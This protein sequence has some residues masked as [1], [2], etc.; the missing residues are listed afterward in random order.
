MVMWITFVS[1]GSE[2]RKSWRGLDRVM[3]YLSG[4]GRGL[5]EDGHA[6]D[7]HSV[8]GGRFYRE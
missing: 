1:G 8:F 4:E 6:W 5:A 7:I 2:D 3:V